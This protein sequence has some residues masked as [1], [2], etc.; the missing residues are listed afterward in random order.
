M[1]GRRLLF[2]KDSGGSNGAFSFF[3]ATQKVKSTCFG[4]LDLHPTSE[5]K[6]QL[7]NN[8]PLARAKAGA[9]PVSSYTDP[10][11]GNKK[12]MFLV[13]DN[14][15]TI[16]FAT[17]TEQERDDWVEV[18]KEAIKGTTHFLPISGLELPPGALGDNV[19]ANS[20]TFGS[21]GVSSKNNGARRSVIPAAV[22]FPNKAGYLK[23]SSQGKGTFAISVVK[24]RWF[25]LAAGELR[26]Y[27]DE[28]ESATKLKEC[29]H[30]GGAQILA[31]P[32]GPSMPALVHVQFT[33]GRSMKLEAPTPKIA[34]EWRDAFAETILLLGNMP[35]PATTAAQKPTRRLN[36]HDFV[37][38]DTPAGGGGGGGGGS[39]SSTSQSPLPANGRRARAATTIGSPNST[40]SRKADNSD[41]DEDAPPP[42]GSFWG[43]M[44]SSSKTS[45][46]PP[47]GSKA[48]SMSTMSLSPAGADGVP[49][50]IPKFAQ[51]HLSA[52]HK[53]A[54]S[55]DL[56]KECLQQN[57][58]VKR[59]PDL[60]PLI[61]LMEDR[62]AV[63][64]EVVIWQGSS[65]DAFYALESGQCDVLKDGRVVS[66][67]TAGK[68]FGELALVNNATRQATI[69]AASVC[70]LWLFTRNQFREVAVAQEVKQTEERILF[71]QQIDLF[72]KLVRSSLEKI[73]D[74]MVL[75]SYATGERIIRQ[76]DTGDAFYM[77][78]SGRVVVSVFFL[79]P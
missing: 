77:I 20:A 13:K 60:Q 78:L 35:T 59:L 26:Y 72:S 17:D 25:R 53:S 39:L 4:Y 55:N 41:S 34:N 68:S 5:V 16:H 49:V 12:Y 43:R 64:G 11:Q 65:G 62:V 10:K 69:R 73:A 54:E 18:I 1:F 57:F 29:I 33:G 61:D 52:T 42:S 22:D 71:L 67:I 8:K 30:L 51:K 50:H 58:L 21:A 3:E 75:K 56:L 45:P 7:L 63:P 2:S 79:L 14:D 15:A 48:R 44:T 24:K 37:P 36:V 66:K 32:T 40:S 31:V 47:L 19:D 9:V 6:K 70:K 38:S 28:D 46:P 27:E 23:K 76:G 74:V